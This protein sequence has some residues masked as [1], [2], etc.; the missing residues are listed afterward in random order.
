MSSLGFPHIR[1]LVVFP[2]MNKP[3][4]SEEVQRIWTDDI[5]L[6][7]VYR[8]VNDN[9][10]QYLPVSYES[11]RLNSRAERIQLATDGLDAADTPLCVAFRSDDNLQ[12]VWA[13]IVSKTQQKGFEEF[14]DA[15]LV[16]L[17]QWHPTATI[18]K[19]MEGA[20]KSLGREW[21]LEMDMNYIPVETVE[22]RVESQYGLSG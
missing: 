2:H 10:A 6:P 1:L 15:F 12:G 16:A 22:V 3:F 8:H 20:W 5:V 21:D 13:D 19:S 14:R 4:D 18:D 9:V 11:L 7:S 17:G